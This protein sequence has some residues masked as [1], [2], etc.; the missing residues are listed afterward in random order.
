MIDE[1]P[2]VLKYFQKTGIKNLV[3]STTAMVIMKNTKKYVTKIWL[4]NFKSYNF[5]R[6][7][8]AFDFAKLFN[9]Q[10]LGVIMKTF[11]Q[12]KV[13]AWIIFGLEF[14]KKQLAMKI[15]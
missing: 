1:E 13:S 4:R 7:R 3:K 11:V 9:A 5:Q 2:T 12:N 14:Y 8:I 15:V 10:K 6:W